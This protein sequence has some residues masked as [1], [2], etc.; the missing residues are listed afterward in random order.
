[1]TRHD[2][3]R[4][5]LKRIHGRGRSEAWRRANAVTYPLR[6]LCAREVLR[7]DGLQGERRAEVRPQDDD[8]GAELRRVA[9]HVLYEHLLVLFGLHQITRTDSSRT[10]L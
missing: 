7:V 9:R 6:M 4:M 3:T 10:I 2:T 5:R 1:M 8:L